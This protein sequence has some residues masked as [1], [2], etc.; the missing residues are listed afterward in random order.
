[1]ALLAAYSVWNDDG[2]TLEEYLDSKVFSQVEA[3]EIAPV[4]A[5]QDSFT[6]YMKRFRAGLAVERIA[7]ENMR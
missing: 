6:N 3:T 1:M 7:A 4:K 5:E 2:V